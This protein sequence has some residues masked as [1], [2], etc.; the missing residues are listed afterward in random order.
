MQSAVSGLEDE[1]PRKVQA[2]NVDC[3]SPEGRAAVKELGFDSHGLAVRDPSGQVLFK[4]ADHAVQVQDVRAAIK[5]S[6]K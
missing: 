1:F 4:Q 2:K 5:R 3:E 6:L